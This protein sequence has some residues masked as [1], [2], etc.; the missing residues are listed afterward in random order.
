M[1]TINK[2]R[3]VVIAI[4]FST[5]FIF[6]QITCSYNRGLFARTGDVVQVYE[7]HQRAN[8]GYLYDII[9]TKPNESEQFYLLID[10]HHN[11]IPKIGE[12]WRVQPTVRFNIAAD[13]LTFVERVK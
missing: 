12:T 3:L 10:A 2:I 8:A 13:N 1:S 5:P 9:V 7:T 4:M 6:Y 11:K